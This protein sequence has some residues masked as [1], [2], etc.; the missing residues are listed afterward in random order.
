MCGLI[1]QMAAMGTDPVALMISAHV[2]TGSM[3]PQRGPTLTALVVPAQGQSPVRFYLAPSASPL[4]KDRWLVRP[5][6]SSL[7]SR[8]PAPSKIDKS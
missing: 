5:C 4:D 2:T 7:P 8:V 6:V 1:V 3:E